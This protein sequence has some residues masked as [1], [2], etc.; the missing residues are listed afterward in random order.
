M[1]SGRRLLARWRGPV[2]P[3]LARLPRLAPTA[4]A[5]GEQRRGAGA[6]GTDSAPSGGY[7]AVWA[8]S[9]S[10]G[11]ATWTPACWPTHRSS[12]RRRPRP[13]AARPTAPTRIPLPRRRPRPPAPGRRRPTRR[14]PRRPGPAPCDFCTLRARPAPRCRR[15]GRRPSSPA[16]PGPTNPRSRRCRRRRRRS[17]PTFPPNT[18]TP[19][20][21]RRH[22]SRRGG[23]AWRAKRC[24]GRRHASRI[25]GDPRPSGA[26]S[27][28]TPG[29]RRRAAS[30]CNSPTRPPAS[31]CRRAP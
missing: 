14:A 7:Y 28:P 17:F 2:V 20:R 1:R 27:I 21:D 23:A 18:P 9:C 24:R 31:G 29:R 12:P 19:R 11:A 8:P 4:R 6:P 16:R 13:A 10:P 25:P 22:Q 30:T 26:S 15:T 3:G 5:A